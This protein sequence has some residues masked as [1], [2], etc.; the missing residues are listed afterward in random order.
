[1]PN[2]KPADTTSSDTFSVWRVNFDQLK[3]AAVCYVESAS[4]PINTDGAP[5]YD[6]LTLWLHTTPDPNEAYLLIDN[7]GPSSAV[8]LK[9]GSVTGTVLSDGSV[10]LTANWNAGA[11]D[12]T[13][14]RFVSTQTT[15]TSPFGVSSTTVV[16]N[17]NADTVDGSHAADLYAR[18][19][20]TG[21]QLLATISDAGTLA[22]VS[23]VDTANI[24]NGAVDNTKLADM[25]AWNIKM[26]GAA[27]TGDPT[28]T[29][30]SGLVEATSIAAGDHLLIEL[31]TG[32]L[33]RVLGSNSGG[34]DNSVT[35]T[36]LADMAAWTLKM[37]AAGTSGDPSDTKI[38]GLTEA[39]V[40]GA[41]D[42]LL[43]ELSTGELRKLSPARVGMTNDTSVKL[44]SFT[45]VAGYRYFV[46][47]DTPGSPSDVIVTLP[48]SPAFGD[49]VEIFHVGLGDVATPS[50]NEALY[51]NPGASWKIMTGANDE[52]LRIDKIG[53]ATRLIYTNSTFGWRVAV[54]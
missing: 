41:T 1:M 4:A 15:G 54:M 8:W 33:R 32:E 44:A 28:D 17:L 34:A 40:I 31:S 5:E 48:A 50:A 36:K 47:T 14:K 16:T 3:D 9:L 19:N 12:I 26:R 35:N 23:S 37:R 45:A 11:F 22:G 21:T 52:D 46:D 51:I 24:T 10:P 20:H 30:I 18:A 29:K 38:S 7:A 49:T 6:N 43:A 13:G 39:T 42:W 27:G 53:A 2:L 25:S